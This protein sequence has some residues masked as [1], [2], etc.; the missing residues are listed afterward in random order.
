MTSAQRTP[1]VAELNATLRIEKLRCKQNPNH[2]WNSNLGD[3]L[4]GIEFDDGSG[5]QD[6]VSA[7]VAI[8]EFMFNQLKL[9]QSATPTRLSAK[10]NEPDSFGM[11]ILHRLLAIGHWESVPLLL[12]NGADPSIRTRELDCFRHLE[13]ESSVLHKRDQRLV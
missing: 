13:H 1:F 8:V 2:L 7:R 5:R 4:R 10:I 9:Q 3:I 11:P 6:F 12:A